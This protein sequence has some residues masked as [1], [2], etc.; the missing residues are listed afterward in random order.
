MTAKSPNEFSTSMFDSGPMWKPISISPFGREL[1]LAV[2]DGDGIHALV[3]PCRRTLTGWMRV[4]TKDR[5]DVS[6]THWRDWM[7]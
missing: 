4:G 6:P 7:A 5:V 3:F 2:I 1:E